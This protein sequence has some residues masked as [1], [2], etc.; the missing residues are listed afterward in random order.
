MEQSI[1]MQTKSS[2]G[3]AG[4][5]NKGWY[6]KTPTAPTDKNKET[7]P[8]FA[9]LNAIKAAVKKG[10]TAQNGTKSVTGMNDTATPPDGVQIQMQQLFLK[11]K[12]M[13]LHQRSF[14]RQIRLVI[15]RILRRL[16]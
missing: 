7:T 10:A 15:Q 6:A 1:L 8:D 3:T 12:H 2:A 9:D 14:L 11:R 13:S 4:K 5:I 16:V